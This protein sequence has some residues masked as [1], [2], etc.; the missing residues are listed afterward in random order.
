MNGGRVILLG[1][2]WE[3]HIV[4]DFLSTVNGGVHFVFGTIVLSLSIWV[5]VLLICL[6]W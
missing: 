1:K 3:G 6:V 4:F 5:F 2:S